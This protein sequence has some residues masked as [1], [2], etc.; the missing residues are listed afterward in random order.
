M[1]NIVECK[2]A[3]QICVVEADINLEFKEPLDY[4]EKAPQQAKQ[5]AMSAEKKAEQE[6][7]SKKKEIMRM[8]KRLD[9]Q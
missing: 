3:D 1:I 9:G 6:L 5:N 2:P 7:E 8:Y 4:V